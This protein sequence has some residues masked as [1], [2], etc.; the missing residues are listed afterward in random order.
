MSA[1]L[2][3]LKLMTGLARPLDSRHRGRGPR[4]SDRASTMQTGT[5]YS[6]HAYRRLCPLW[7]SL[8]TPRHIRYRVL[9][10]GR[11][12]FEVAQIVLLLVGVRML[13]AVQMIQRTLASRRHLA[14]EQRGTTDSLQDHE[15]PGSHLVSTHRQHQSGCR[16]RAIHRI[17]G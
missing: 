16:R 2:R 13:L 1:S 8:D 9:V 10:V 15:R 17:E 6:V 4:T 12:R 14:R 11:E 5:A 7:E 3:L